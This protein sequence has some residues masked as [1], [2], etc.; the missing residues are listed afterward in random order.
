MNRRGLFSAVLGTAVASAA[1]NPPD[2]QQEP[3]GE[4]RCIRHTVAGE[5]GNW[6][7]MV[8]IGG[9]DVT[10]ICC[11]ALEW[12]DGLVRVDV[13]AFSEIPKVNGK[14]VF[15]SGIRATFEGQGKIT[16]TPK[17]ASPNQFRRY[18]PGIIT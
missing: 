17:P 5:T 9:Q 10:N 6:D 18:I 13:V 16:L 4:P 1:N 8:E 11:E 7:V 15:Q 3:K 12:D 2:I 14:L